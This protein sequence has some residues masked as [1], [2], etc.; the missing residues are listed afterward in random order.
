M[1]GDKLKASW[2]LLKCIE[3][4]IS[5]AAEGEKTQNLAGVSIT[6]SCKKLIQIKAKQDTKLNPPACAKFSKDKLSPE[7]SLPLSEI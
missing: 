7:S 3:T 5:R 2:E 4:L 1:Y 6:R